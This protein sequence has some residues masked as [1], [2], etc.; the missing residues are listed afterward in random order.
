MIVRYLVCGE[1][2][3]LSMVSVESFPLTLPVGKAARSNAAKCV[4]ADTRE[5]RRSCRDQS[6]LKAF[7]SSSLP[8]FHS[9]HKPP[10][11]SL[12]INQLR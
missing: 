4:R 8:T 10:A 1:R 3:D 6:L 5:S 12:S 11:F 7:K 9:C 2:R